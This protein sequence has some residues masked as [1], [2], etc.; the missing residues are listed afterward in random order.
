MNEPQLIDVMVVMFLFAVV[1]V[2]YSVAILT[3]VYPYNN[4]EYS[5]LWKVIGSLWMDATYPGP[6]LGSLTA[7][8]TA[9]TWQSNLPT[10]YQLSEWLNPGN[11]ICLVKDART[12]NATYSS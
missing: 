11:E 2:S 6:G 1:L 10:G 8:G 3:L 5:L 12:I 4:F 7:T 9:F